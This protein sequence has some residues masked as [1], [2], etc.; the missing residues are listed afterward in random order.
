M[1]TLLIALLAA[2]GIGGIAYALIMLR[3]DKE[4]EQRLKMVVGDTSAQKKSGFMQKLFDGTKEDRRRKLEQTLREMQD[5]QQKK[6]QRITLRQR[7]QRAGL[8]TSEQQFY[9]LALGLG[10]IMGIIGMA[11]GSAMGGMQ[12]GIMIGA[13]LFVIGALGLPFWLLGFLTRRR[14]NQFLMLLPDAVELMVRGLR[15]GLPATD[16]M[17]TIAE[18]IPDPVGPEFREVVEGQKLGI[19]MD[20]GLERMYERVPLPEVNFLSIAIAIQKETG[21]NLSEAL[22]NLST[23]LR[24][25]KAMKLKVKAITQEAKVSAYIVG[26]LPILLAGGIMY[27]NPD[28]MEKFFNTSTGNLMGLFAIGLMG[29]GILIMR[30]MIN[31]RF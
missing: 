6:K 28:H 22:E 2:F 13:A 1:G 16:A 25:R 5:K 29:T 24:A 18:E 4:E 11:L 10:A 31:F 21:G 17:R 20:Q 3:F 8:Q 23:V 14:M 26:S 9:M 7:L 19:P 30:K 12:I 15:S 27:L